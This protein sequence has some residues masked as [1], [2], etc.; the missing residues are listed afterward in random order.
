MRVY[1]LEKKNFT[2][3]W[4]I[5]WRKTKPKK[6][7][8]QR[9]DAIE[10]KKDIIRNKEKSK[11]VIILKLVDAQSEKYMYKNIEHSHSRTRQ[12]RFVVVIFLLLLFESCVA[13]TG[14]RR[15]PLHI[16]YA[17]P[18]S[19]PSLSSEMQV[20]MWVLLRDRV[21]LFD[22]IACMRTLIS[23]SS[24]APLMLMFCWFCFYSYHILHRF[25]AL[26]LHLFAVILLYCESICV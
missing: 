15:S 1:H 16:W 5:K 23:L 20:N 17:A 10:N 8:K 22:V 26:R 13:W 12:T 4:I 18:S 14:S 25:Y 19:L 2:R 6:Y 24:Y 3:S 11:A 7:C 9:I 21:C